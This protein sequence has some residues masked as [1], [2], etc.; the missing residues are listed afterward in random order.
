MA[1]RR[2]IV[3]GGG[4]VGASVALGLSGRGWRVALCDAGRLGARSTSRAAGVVSDLTWSEQDRQWVAESRERYAR[5]PGGGESVV[6]RTGSLAWAA[7]EDTGRL[8]AHAERLARA[9]VALEEPTAAALEARYPALC[10]FEGGGRALYLPEDGVTDAATYA[11]AAGQAVARAG[12]EVLEETPVSL[13]GTADGEAPGVRLPDGAVRRADAVVV[14]A[15]AWTRNILAALGVHA[16]LRPYRTHLGV[17]THPRASDLPRTVLHDIA[18]DWYWVPEAPGRLLAGDGTELTESDPD[19]FREAPDAQFL[20]DIA[21][22]LARRTLGGDQATL[23]RAY[24]GILTATPDRRPL[25]GPV[26]S[27]PGVWIAAGMNG[28]GVMRGP[29]VGAA[30][31]AALSE[32][33]PQAL[34]ADCRPERASWDLPPDFPI[35][36]GY[37]L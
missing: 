21:D 6:R 12:G 24:A 23:G 2:A 29:A 17:V 31:A 15:G 3:V 7:G 11:R 5:P 26:P 10:L 20:E 19:S 34:P 13:L 14:A 30:V 1:E 18:L 8:R 22:R 16:P 33:R 9:G 28:F 25:L 32:G 4:I 36:P 37:T 35:R 27:R